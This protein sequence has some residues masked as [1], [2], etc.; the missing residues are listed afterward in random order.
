MAAEGRIRENL[1]QQMANLNKVAKFYTNK[2]KPLY[3]MLLESVLKNRSHKVGVLIRAANSIRKLKLNSFNDFG[4]QCHTKNSE[5][6]FY[7]STYLY[8]NSDIQLDSPIAIPVDTNGICYIAR[9]VDDVS[10]IDRI[11]ECMSWNMTIL[12]IIIECILIR[13]SLP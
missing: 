5:P 13:E 4:E 3:G 6:Y 12:I 10:C 7:E 2:I 11:E 1:Y 9:I 8:D